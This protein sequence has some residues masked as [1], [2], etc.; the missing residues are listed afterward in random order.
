LPSTYL[1]T[2]ANSYNYVN[3][4]E[5]PQRSHSYPHQYGNADLDGNT[6]QFTH[7]YRIPDSNMDRPTYSYKH[8]D[9]FSDD[10]SDSDSN[11][12]LYAQYI[13]DSRL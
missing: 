13:V 12:D 4:H 10:F 2:F 9:L 3:L 6:H 11:I 7:R 8:T 5:Y 1:N